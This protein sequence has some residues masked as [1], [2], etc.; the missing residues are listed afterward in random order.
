MDQFSFLFSPAA[1]ALGYTLLYSIGQA[2]VVFICLR[3]VLKF[4]PNAS[5]HI[6][7]SLSYCGYLAIGAW[8]FITLFHQFS[9]AQSESVT[10]KGNCRKFF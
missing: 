1:A 6:K 5:S 3:I 8:F 7:Y 9:I 10:S 4:I 2:F